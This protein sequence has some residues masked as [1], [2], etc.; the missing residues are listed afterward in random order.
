MYL[1]LIEN[2]G[3]LKTCLSDG[4]FIDTAFSIELIKFLASVGLKKKNQDW[5]VA[6]GLQI[7]LTISI[8]VSNAV[9]DSAAKI[10]LPYKKITN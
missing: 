7:L 3:C 4:L 10:I 2:Q 6:K 9:V 5:T 1:P 8:G